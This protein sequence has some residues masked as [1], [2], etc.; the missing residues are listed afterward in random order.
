MYTIFAY[1]GFIFAG[2]LILLGFLHLNLLEIFVIV[3]FA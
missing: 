2:F 3:L 1:L